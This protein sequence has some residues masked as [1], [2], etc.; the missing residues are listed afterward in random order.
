MIIDPSAIVAVLT[1]EPD[2]M[3][4]RDAIYDA[5]TVGLSA[6]G[7][8]EVGVVLDNRGL[9]AELDQFLAWCEATIEPVTV[10][11]ARLARWA[12]TRFGRGSGHPARLNYG[13]CFSYAL[14]MDKR[15]PL[16]FKGNDFSETDVLVA[17]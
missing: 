8:V 2:G 12:H 14:A 13:D 7:L 5:R 1:R 6:A 11:Q 4:F 10:A 3:R 9:A 16:L 15:E 17:Q